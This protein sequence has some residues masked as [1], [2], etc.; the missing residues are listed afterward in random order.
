[1]SDQPNIG[2]RMASDAHDKGIHHDQ[3]VCPQCVERREVEV[4]RR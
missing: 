4:V 1:M 2:Q 3:S